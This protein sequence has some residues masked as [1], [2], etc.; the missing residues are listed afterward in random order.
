VKQ[1]NCECGVTIKWSTPTGETPELISQVIA[2]EHWKK[3]HEEVT[4]AECREIRE[5]IRKRRQKASYRKRNGSSTVT[6]EPIMEPQRRALTKL[7][8]SGVLS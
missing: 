1:F 6:V 4:A 5:A 8:D 7:L 3:G 2:T